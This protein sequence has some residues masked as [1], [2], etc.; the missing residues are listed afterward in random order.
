MLRCTSLNMPVGASWDLLYSLSKRPIFLMQ[1]VT[2]CCWCLSRFW[3]KSYLLSRG[4]QKFRV[5][6]AFWSFVCGFELWDRRPWT[7]FHGVAS[8]F[9]F[10]I[11]SIFSI[12]WARRAL[13]LAF[14]FSLIL[15]FSIC[16]SIADFNYFFWLLELFSTMFATSW[17]RTTIFW[18]FISEFSL[19]C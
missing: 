14:S 3:S 19:F 15:S 6:F 9:S 1:L 2:T 11:L 18:R 10:R 13:R 7:G 4:S 5:F 8:S 16:I 12:F 17:L